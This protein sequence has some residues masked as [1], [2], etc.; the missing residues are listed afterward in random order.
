MNTIYTVTLITYYFLLILN[1]F[2]FTILALRKAKKLQSLII[3]IYLWCMLLIQVTSDVVSIYTSNNLYFSHIFF[4]FHFWILGFYYYSSFS[5]KKQRVL[6]QYYMSLTSLFVVLQF[7]IQN[8]LWYRF[9][10]IEVFFTNY[11]FVICA[12]FFMYNAFSSK[13]KNQY[14]VLNL[15]VLIYSILSLSIF[16]FGNVMAQI[17]L[18]LT[19]YTWLIYTCILIFFHLSILHQWKVLFYEKDNNVRPS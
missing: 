10:L 16:L 3:T 2:L 19:I 1:T 15:G 13:A 7:F 17:D 5:S 6:I 4:F 11:F 18:D 12:L 14:G 9:S 8:G